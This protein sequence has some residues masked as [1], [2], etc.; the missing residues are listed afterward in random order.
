[1]RP[2]VLDI[3]AARVVEYLRVFSQSSD[4]GTSDA[5]AGDPASLPQ[6]PEVPELPR[7]PGLKPPLARAAPQK[8]RGESGEYRKMGIAYSIPAALIAPIVVLTLGGWWLDGR[9]HLSPYGTLGGA[10][11]GTVSGFIN[12]IRIAGKLNE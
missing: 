10:L 5:E 8:E 9:F 2:D 3:R 7:P 1:M 11:L 4:D 12:M 6:V